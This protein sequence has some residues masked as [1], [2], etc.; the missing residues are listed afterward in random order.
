MMPA[1]IEKMKPDEL[2][3]DEEELSNQSEDNVVDRLETLKVPPD[4]PRRQYVTKFF[5][6]MNGGEYEKLTT[7][8]H[9]SAAEDYFFHVNSAPSNEIRTDPNPYLPKSLIINGVDTFVNFM[10]SM[11]D[12]VPDR[13]YT[14]EDSIIRNRMDGTLIISQFVV[15]GTGVRELTMKLES[16]SIDDSSPFPTRGGKVRYAE[17]NTGGKILTVEEERQFKAGGILK[18]GT[19]FIRLEGTSTMTLN[20]AGKICS[21]L[22]D[23]SDDRN[24]NWINVFD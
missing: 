17:F 1:V 16:T 7:F 23:F 14:L 10:N 3:D 8:L 13:F 9:E 11:G 12:C 6:Y 20:S 2:T 24:A 19:C 4:D 18:G 15:M 22:W 5:Q 21:V